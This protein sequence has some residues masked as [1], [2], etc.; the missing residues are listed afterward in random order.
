MILG[1][2]TNSEFASRK[3]ERPFPV[4]Q[5][6]WLLRTGFIGAL[7]LFSCCNRAQPEKGKG[8]EGDKIVPLAIE[9]KSV[10]ENASQSASDRSQAANPPAAKPTNQASLPGDGS[11]LDLSTGFGST[12]T[13]N[14]SGSEQPVLPPGSSG[15]VADVKPGVHIEMAEPSLPSAG[16]DT[17]TSEATDEL[18][19]RLADR[20]FMQLK[21]P[22]ST[23]PQVLIAFLVQCDRAVQDLT[24]TRQAQQLSE[25][26]F[27]IQAKRLSGMKLQ[28][29]ERM[30][31]SSTLTPAQNKAATAARVE[32]LSQLTGLGDVEA[33]QKLQQLATELSKSND[34]YL[35]HQGK[36]VLLGFRLNQLQEGQIKDPQMLVAEVD[37]LFLRPE[38]RGLVELMALQQSAGVLS[39]L[40]YTTESKQIID[41]LVREYRDSPDKDLSMRAW[42]LESG[43]SSALQAF[44]QA[45]RAL[46]DGTDSDPSKI[47]TAAAQ[48]IGAFPSLNTLVYC[49][50]FMLDLEFSGNVAAASEMAQAIT[51]ARTQFPPGSFSADIDQFLDCHSRRMAA[52]GK[53]L[54]LDELVGFDGRAFDWSTYRGKVVLVCFWASWEINS[55]EELRQMKALRDQIRD[56]DFEI[57]GI[58]LDDA[59]LSNAQQT[60]IGQ[61]YTW[62][63]VRSNRA[64]AI[65]FNTP[66][67]KALGVNA[68]P[69]MLLVDK[70][71]IVAAIHT[72][73]QKSAGK[74]RELLE[75]K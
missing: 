38:D 51:A 75:K 29:A 8:A 55:L 4:S 23:D 49:S 61:N 42:V 15:L 12:P 33:A 63:N 70:N 32:S 34:H 26:D 56:T 71:G 53:P 57:V 11:L 20:V 60:V 2:S 58:N 18:S 13:V 48:L 72:R 41:R 54:N 17:T 65:G 67:A 45:H 5:H 28:A 68:V 73:S 10:D 40:G 47:A 66:A 35:A 21:M 14:A 7:L 24:V 1:T 52:R 31:A 25:T 62:R 44:H 36:L 16:V 46:L 22:T 74:I 6:R 64:D 39:Q 9:N 27:R 3:A 43:G 37:Q 69:F 30:L 59:Y 19:Q 50:R